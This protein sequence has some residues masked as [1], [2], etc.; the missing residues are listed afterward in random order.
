M[1]ETNAVSHLSNLTITTS[2]GSLW[3][4]FC[5]GEQDAL[6]LIY[7]THIDDLYHYGMHFCRD[8]E[9]VKDCLQDLFQCLWLD[10]EHL[11][12][13]VKNIRYYLISSLRRRLLRSLE[14]TR[15]HYTEELG[16][17]F[18]F[19]LVA[20]R[21]DAIIQDETYR[22]QIKQLHDGIEM[23]SRRQREAIY[24]R[25]YQNLSYE[26]IAKLMVMKVE[27]VYNIISKAIGL[28]KN[29]LLFVWM[30]TLLL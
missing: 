21:E 2:A 13:D 25:F 6:N 22:Q 24:L 14:N 19:R 12:N 1:N 17:T 29:M 8:T 23:L 20:P 15:R 16:D 30:I 11:S 7:H 27:S 28:L 10:R 18:D 5:K 9:R 4:R 26:E 3:E